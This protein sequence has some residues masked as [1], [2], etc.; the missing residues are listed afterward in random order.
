M[1]AARPARVLIAGAGIA[2]LTAA[3]SLHAA[4]ITDVV[5]HEAVD[6]IQPLGVGINIL[7]HA[8]RELIELGLGERLAGIG[9]PTADLTFINRRGQRIWS[10]PRGRNAGYTWPQ[11]SIHRGRLQLMLLQAVRERLGDD[12]VVTGSPVTGLDHDADLLIG[13]DGIRSNVRAAL[14]PDEGEPLWGGYVLWRGTAYAK[15]FMTGKSMIMAGDGT[16]KLVIYPIAPPEPDGTQLI[17]WAIQH[18]APETT[19]RGD[20]N[21]QV[22][23]G[24]FIDHVADCHFDELDIPALIASADKAYE[25]PLVDRDPLP[26]WSRGT[27][28]LMGDAA[29]PMYPTGSNGGTQAVI[30]A[31]VLAY[32]LATG[33]GLDFYEETRRPLTNG[34]VLA[35]REDGPEVIL[36]LAHER[37]PG[38]FT[39]IE[40]VIPLAEREE[41][42]LH[43]KRLAG[44]EP[45]TLNA[46]PSWTVGDRPA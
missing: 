41:I 34:V 19:P 13:A 7:P 21:R 40:Q 1:T 10:E 17:N 9:I 43:Y 44:F 20:W 27:V 22:E 39:D 29:H 25:Y 3:L 11:Y 18:R 14:F 2:G 38:G 30:D 46:R 45:A 36:K 31:R 8:V 24:K 35:N 26:H 33:R 5:V 6:D 28:T 16:Q 42:A 32:A 37:A 4:G 23:V 15:P 12:A